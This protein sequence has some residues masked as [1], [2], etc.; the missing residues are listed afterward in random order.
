MKPFT[1][2]FGLRVFALLTFIV[3]ALSCF[4]Q[5]HGITPPQMVH[6]NEPG[7]QMGVQENE[8][9][10]VTTDVTGDPV[11]NPL[12]PRRDSFDSVL[13]RGREYAHIGEHTSAF[14][15]T[16]AGMRPLFGLTS[17]YDRRYR[18]GAPTNEIFQAGPFFIRVTDVEAAVLVSDNVNFT[19]D[20]AHWGALAQLKMRLL[21][22]LQISPTWRLSVSGSII[23][24][25]FDNE[26]GVEG[27][28]IGD[29]VGFI[30]EERLRPVT[31]FQLAYASRWADWNVQASDDF[32]V[33]YVT[34]GAGY[35]DF[36]HGVA[37]P[38]GVHAE[39]TAGR[40]VFGNGT[41]IPNQNVNQRQG[42]FLNVRTFLSLENTITGVA[43]RMVPSD[44]RVAFGASHSDFWY[45]GSLDAGTNGLGFSATSVDRVFAMFRN[46][47][48]S[49]RFKPYGYY[50]AYRY[51]YDPNW[52]HQ[53]GV[54]FDGPITDYLWIR[55]EGGYQWGGVL[56]HNTEQYRIRL[57]HEPTPIT[58]EEVIYSRVATEPVR[59]V[60]DTYRYQLYQVL[61]K[62]LWGRFAI[63]RSVFMPN[64]A[65]VFESVED[66]M[67]TR[68]IYQPTI[69]HTLILGGSYAEDRFANPGRDR[70]TI[71]EARAQIRYQYS[72][73][74]RLAFLYRYANVNTR[75]GKSETDI[76]ENLWLFTARRNF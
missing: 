73:T 6:V 13:V 76:G 74:L 15:G 70:Q 19:P 53:F 34:L 29:A 1:G 21:A 18:R 23:Y 20:N 5:N 39:D 36:V 17:L 8:G 63:Q 44:T 7:F 33:S 4:G 47:H 65:G 68:I 60:R 67:A 2:G 32:T 43:S 46:E 62:D 72:P 3:A 50:D 55:A 69:R 35:D 42:D 49:M 41:T 14:F 51:N 61:G 45:H 37:Q 26:F 71:W 16:R 24:L 64:Q 59:E 25:P 31:H 28:G 38:G 12:A 40:Y 58:R 57:I 52:T 48:E 66:R 27:F 30:A 22:I 54:G 9:T 11:I 10:F 75:Q 56:L